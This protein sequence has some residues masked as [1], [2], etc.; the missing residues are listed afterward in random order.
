MNA[1]ECLRLVSSSTAAEM[2]G[3]STRTMQ[4]LTESGALPT[5]RMTPKSGARWVSVEAL[6][7]FVANGG[8]TPNAV[9]PVYC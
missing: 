1:D 6:R 9:T 4:R 3:V 8:V 5:V 7:R 2:L